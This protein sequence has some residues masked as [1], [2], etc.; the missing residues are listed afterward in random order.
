MLPSVTDQEVSLVQTTGM[1]EGRLVGL[2]FTTLGCE[3][4]NLTNEL[5]LHSSE[6]KHGYRFRNKHALELLDRA[7]NG[8][9]S[10]ED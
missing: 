9:E 8:P 7:E 6:G 4:S 5:A 3:P 1:K 2:A 10:R